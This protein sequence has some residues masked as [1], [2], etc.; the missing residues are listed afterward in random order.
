MAFK[1][2]RNKKA[3]V[4]LL[5]AVG[6]LGVCIAIALVAITPQTYDITVGE[7]SPQTITAPKD[8]VDEVTTQAK[9]EDCLLYTSR[10]V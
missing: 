10:C 7:I 6:S 4:N 1:S 2:E 3:F 9:V 8:V 5:M